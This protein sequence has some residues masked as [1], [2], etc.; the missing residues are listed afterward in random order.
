I[1]S[2]LKQSRFVEDGGIET[3]IAGITAEAEG[4]IDAKVDSRQL[5]LVPRAL[6]DEDPAAGIESRQNSLVGRAGGEIEG[7]KI[8]LFGVA[9]WRIGDGVLSPALHKI[10]RAPLPAF[11]HAI[12]SHLVPALRPP[13]DHH[14]VLADFAGR[15]R[16]A[17]QRREGG[18][19]F[20]YLPDAQ[21]AAGNLKGAAG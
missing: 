20:V 6:L 11:E 13:A 5:P 3:G 7:N 14:H 4:P 17:I 9:L 18:E 8:A 15:R 16:R 10:G 19:G 2:H 12:D 1:R 21:I